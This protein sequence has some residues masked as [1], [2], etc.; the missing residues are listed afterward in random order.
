VF[1]LA[2]ASLV[3]VAAQR[4]GT[5][6]ESRDHPAIGYS[7]ATMKDPIA[8][9]GAEIR[10]GRARLTF[11]PDNGYLRSLLEALHVPI[12]SQVVVFSGTSKQ[13]ELITARNPRALYFSDAAAIGWVRGASELEMMAVDPAHGAVF[14]TLDQKAS[15]RPEFRREDN[16]CLTCH[17]TW[18]TL[19]VPGMVTMSVFSVPA[20]DDK[21]SYASGTFTDHRSP[22][23]ERWGG[24][25]VTGKTGSVRHLGNDTDLTRADRRS[26]PKALALESLK[27]SFDLRGFVSP[28]SDVAALMVLEHQSTMTNLITRTGWEAR[29]SEAPG[30]LRA[31][32]PSRA[33]GASAGDRLSEAATELVDY[34]LFV[35]EAPFAGTVTGSSAF[36]ERFAASGPRDAQGRSLRQLDLHH[37]L[38]RFPCSYLIYSDAFDQLPS[39]ATEAV[40]QRLWKVLSGQESGPPYNRLTRD[41]RVA[42]VEILK[43]TRKG[44]PEYFQPQAIIK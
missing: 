39:R 12:E 44:L 27:G 15:D 4:G 8:R 21:Y 42:V 43:A 36:A 30:P 34:M 40:Y 35:D 6:S 2:L 38:M 32:Q 20:P 7:T 11:D 29:V 9:L 14:Y 33:G 23:G 18:D 24:W 22:F 10:E 5:F 28:H 13:A 26:T 1:A 41:D 17:L 19:A 3:A 25:Y 16:T 31:P 37:R